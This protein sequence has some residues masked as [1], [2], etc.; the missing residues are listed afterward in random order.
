MGLDPNQIATIRGS[1]QKL[2]VNYLMT[3]SVR[4]LLGAG[5]LNVGGDGTISA[6]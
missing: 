6:G 3:V 5:T 2:I 4:N 1:G